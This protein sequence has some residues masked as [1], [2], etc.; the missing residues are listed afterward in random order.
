MRTMTAEDIGLHPDFL[1]RMEQER[2]FDA[3]LARIAENQRQWK[4]WKANHDARWHGFFE[5]GAA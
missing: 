4:A 1:C 3:T 2:A 5:Q